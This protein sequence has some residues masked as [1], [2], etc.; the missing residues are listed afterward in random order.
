MIQAASVIRALEAVVRTPVCG[1]Y[2]RPVKTCRRSTD[3][4]ARITHDGSSRAGNGAS[5]ACV[6][7]SQHV[8][9]A[10]LSYE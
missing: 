4:G 5:N 8:H 6:K 9:T 10:W 3:K 2:R 1:P 7:V